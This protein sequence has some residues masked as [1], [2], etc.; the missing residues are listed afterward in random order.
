MKSYLSF[1][2]YTCFFIFIP[3][4]FLSIGAETNNENDNPSFINSFEED[5]TG[6]QF[7]E[8]FTLNGTLLT[9]ESNFYRDVWVDITS[10]FSHQWKISFDGGYDPTLELIDLNHDHTLDLF[11]Q[12]AKDENKLQHFYQL[13]TLKN[14]VVK[15]LPLPKHNHIQAK[16]LSNFQVEIQIDPNKKPIK[17]D[18]SASKEEYVKQSIY[19]KKGKLLKDK[20]INITPISFI[21]PILLS[22]SKGYGL[23][24]YQTIN[25]LSDEDVLGQI[26][27][28]WYYQNDEWIILKSKM[29]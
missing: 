12:V 15:Q 26:V 29:D 7:R 14:G 28:I 6:D 10:P 21:E 16:F 1:I 18:I 25:G 19:N 3:N 27:T 24:S 2:L 20:K 17:K 11:Y 9:K 4:P 5:L 8:L 13:Y 23:K 22:K